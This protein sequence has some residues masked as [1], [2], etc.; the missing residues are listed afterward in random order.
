MLNRIRYAFG[1]FAKKATVLEC[2]LSKLNGV[3]AA[4]RMDG[5]AAT[6]LDLLCA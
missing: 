6:C 2:V 1:A 4:G 3:T 5:S